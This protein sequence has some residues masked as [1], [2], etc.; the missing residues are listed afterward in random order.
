MASIDVFLQPVPSDTAAA[1]VRL[2]SALRTLQAAPGA[3]AVSGVA[4]AILFA[5]RMQAAPGA[6]SVAAAANTWLQYSGITAQHRLGALGEFAFGQTYEAQI[7]Y[8][9][10]GG[11]ALTLSGVNATLTKVTPRVMATAAGAFSLTGVG[12]RVGYHKLALDAGGQYMAGSWIYG[13]T[14]LSYTYEPVAASY[15]IQGV[16]PMRAP[17]ALGQFAL[18]QGTAGVGGA[19]LNYFVAISAAAGSFSLSPKTVT[20]T[21]THP[22]AAA[23]GAFSLSGVAQALTFTRYISAAAGAFSLAGV[24]QTLTYTSGG[25]KTISAAAGAFVLSGV[26]QS[27]LVTHQAQPAAG[28][29]TL[30]GVAQTLTFKRVTTTATGAFALSGVAQTLQVNHKITCAAGA[31][32]LNGVAVTLTYTQSVKTI[33]AAPGAF[34]LAGV[35]QALNLTRRVTTAAGAFTLAGVAVTLNRPRILGTA[36]GAFTLAGVAQTLKPSRL[37][38]AAPGAFVLSGVSQALTVAHKM[39]TAAGTFVLAGVN[40]SLGRPRVFSVA[41]GAFVLAPVAASLLQKHVISPAVRAFALS[42]VP[43]SLTQILSAAG[44][45]FAIS[46]VAATLKVVHE[47]YPAAGALTITPQTAGLYYGR[48]LAAAAGAF[49]LTGYSTHGVRTFPVL[50]SAF[51]LASS[52]ATFKWSHVLTAQ[53]GTAVQFS[54]N[55]GSV[56]MTR[57]VTPKRT[58]SVASINFRITGHSLTSTPRHMAVAP[59]VISVVGVNAA[60]T[61]PRRIFSPLTGSFVIQGAT[62]SIGVPPGRAIAWWDNS[63]RS[64]VWVDAQADFIG[65]TDTALSSMVWGAG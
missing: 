35:A 62:A 15:V 40:V 46:G 34:V 5:H 30:S 11:G 37:I 45:A 10:T 65:G 54:L 61:R 50:S 22:L 33:S 52:P 42:G 28:A 38:A 32:T 48:R 20:F 63:A 25:P 44:G 16:D 13:G 1:D 53:V 58:M 12:A 8:L 31:F 7:Y 57:V 4:Q 18:G 24:A 64:N 36:A 41:S 47:L 49:T 43:A 59:G 51:T 60:L 29:F 6:L 26:A 9:D 55:P 39:P 19:Q 21:Y 14:G 2:Y 27:L 56:V 23:A 3:L 17:A